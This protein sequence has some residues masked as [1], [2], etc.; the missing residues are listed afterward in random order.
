MEACCAVVKV[1]GVAGVGVVCAGV[2]V[3]TGTYRV[4]V[5]VIMV[6]AGVSSSHDDRGFSTRMVS[7]HGGSRLVS[8][9]SGM[10]TTL[11]VA[12]VACSCRN[13]SIDRDDL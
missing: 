13:G 7:G 9:R 1:A 2:E 6:V 3:L 4:F 5:T 10:V 8:E 12:A 11:R